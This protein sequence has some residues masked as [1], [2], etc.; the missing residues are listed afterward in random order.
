MRKA[1]LLSALLCCAFDAATPRAQSNDVRV[2][3]LAEE[4]ATE[5]APAAKKE[6]KPT[7]AKS[8]AKSDPKRG[9]QESQK[10]SSETRK[11]DPEKTPAVVSANTNAALPSATNQPSTTSDAPAKSPDPLPVGSPASGTFA[12]KTSAPA[13]TG[14]SQPPSSAAVTAPPLASAVSP[15]SIYRIG[16]GDVLDIRLLNDTN[17]R[18]ST[19]YTVMA[20]GVLE[21]PLAGDPLN[22]AGMTTEELA[23]QLIAE[24]KRRAVYDKPQVRVSVREYASHTVMVSGLAADPGAKVLRREAVP[25]YVVIAEAQPKPEAARAVVISHTNGQSTTIDLNDANGMNV[26]VYPGDVVTLISRPPEFYFIGGMITSPGQK[27]FHAGLTLTQAVLAS[28]GVT[29]K[30]GASV[31]VSRQGA[32]GRLVST[33]YVL[34]QIEEGKIPDPVLRPGDRVEVSARKK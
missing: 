18:A 29:V 34:Q 14:S 21:Y 31:K 2:G 23:G 15:T 9:S 8:D 13:T 32:D 17:T 25:L 27:D 1:L 5:G 28:G 20:G 6:T 16:A 24:L 11:A 26:L 7:V 12:P 10:P 33:E 19:L 3:P 22:V 4:R 30:T